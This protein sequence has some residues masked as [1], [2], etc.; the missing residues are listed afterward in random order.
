MQPSYKRKVD[1]MVKRLNIL[2]DHI[3][4]EELLTDGTLGSML[5]LS[6][7]KKLHLPPLKHIPNV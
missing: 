2:F 3:N 1:D 6:Q 7:G 5:E 4:N